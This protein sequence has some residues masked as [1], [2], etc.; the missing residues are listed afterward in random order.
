MDIPK[1]C[2]SQLTSGSGL[3]R[4]SA[5][6]LPT[7]CDSSTR[8]LASLWWHNFL[9]LIALYCRISELRTFCFQV[10]NV[11]GSKVLLLQEF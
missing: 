10:D 9:V 7:S 4:S 11:I 3:V 2:K 8:S 5:L 6:L 1:M